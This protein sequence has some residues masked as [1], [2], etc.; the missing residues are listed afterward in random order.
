MRSRL[1]LFIAV[2]VVILTWSGLPFPEPAE[3]RASIGTSQQAAEIPDRSYPAPKGHSALLVAAAVYDDLVLMV[4]ERGLIYR[5]TDAGK[6]FKQIETPTRR[7][8]CSVTLGKG[9]LAYAV[10]PDM[11]VLRSRDGGLNWQRVHGDPAA[12]LALFSVVVLDDGKVI[13]VG[14][15]GTVLISEDGGEQWQQQLISEDGPHLYSIQETGSGLV[16]VGEFGSIFHSQDGAGNW[17]AAESPYEGTF[18]HVVSLEDSG[19]LLLLGLR[20]NLWEGKDGDWKRVDSGSEA[21]LFGGSI[22]ADGE[23]VV[24]GDEGRVLIRSV[25]GKWQDQ[26]PGERRLLS[27]AV[28]LPDG[29]VL[30]VGEKGYRIRWCGRNPTIGVEGEGR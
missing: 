3:G 12:D 8:L 1:L 24:V 15:F 7:M 5:S 27:S 25:D 20:G 13:A 17:E 6:N 22:L 23:V 14:S 10:G 11:P 30:V 2:L 16:V 9:G 4:G 21:S 28:A 29:S 26:S 18:F 19:S